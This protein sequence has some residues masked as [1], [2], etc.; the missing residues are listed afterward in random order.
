M[1]DYSICPNMSVCD[2]VSFHSMSILGIARFFQFHLELERCPNICSM[3][4]DRKPFFLLYFY[5]L[6]VDH[7]CL[8]LHTFTF[9]IPIVECECEFTMLPME[10][11]PFPCFTPKLKLLSFPMTA[12]LY[13]A[14]KGLLLLELRQTA[15]RATVG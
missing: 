12:S 7:I 2:R 11:I 15:T 3:R 8:V 5:Q 4:S 14:L 1:Y 13:A 9:H 6:L 10:A